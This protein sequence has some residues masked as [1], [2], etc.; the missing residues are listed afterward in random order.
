M[1]ANRIILGVLLAFIALNAF[2][3]GYYALSG[4]ENVPLEWLQGS[5]FT[6]YFFPGLFLF[7]VVGGTCTVSAIAVFKDSRHARRLSFFCAALLLSWIIIQVSI[8]GYVSW[9]QPAIFLSAVAIILLA[10]LLPGRQVFK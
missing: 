9:M 1:K 7:I 4:A 2:G 10:R 5:P 8:I 6:T 3:G